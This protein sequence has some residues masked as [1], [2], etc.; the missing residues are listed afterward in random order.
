MSTVLAVPFIIAGVAT[1][2]TIE[3]AFRLPWT[4]FFIELLAKFSNAIQAFTA[5]HLTGQ[6]Q[7]IALRK[8]A[9]G[10]LIHTSM[11]LCFLSLILAMAY[12]L[13]IWLQNLYEVSL[14]DWSFIIVL[15]LTGLAY[16]WMRSK[17]VGRVNPESDEASDETY[18]PVSKGTSQIRARKRI[19]F[20]IHPRI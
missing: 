14:A 3:L 17:L 5:E 20:K 4:R 8:A 10:L 7:E 9:L 1:A 11:G 18:S 16:M 19:G 6:E 15:T 12:G 13:E 2:L